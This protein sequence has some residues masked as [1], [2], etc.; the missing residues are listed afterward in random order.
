MPDN[1]A[2]RKSIRAKEK[3]VK[4]TEAL[5]AAVIREVM[6]TTQ[7]RAW[8]WSILSDCH[9]FHT[10]FTG[11]ALSSAFSEGERNIGQRLLNTITDTCPDQY[12]QAMREHHE[13][14]TL[15]ER[16]SSPEP[17]GRDTGSGEAGDGD[18]TFS[19]RLYNDDSDDR[20]DNWH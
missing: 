15:G 13:R 3:Q 4:I 6:S 16:R 2:D 19:H 7:G 10:T 18:E 12:I 14:D 17:N 5:H 9:I 8:I 11:D 1:A 20:L